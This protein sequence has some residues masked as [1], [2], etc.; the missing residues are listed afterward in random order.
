[1]FTSRRQQEHHA[2]Q[3]REHAEALK[4]K[5]ERREA[6]ERRM[7]KQTE[8]A[9]RLKAQRARRHR[10]MLEEHARRK[11]KGG[12]SGHSSWSEYDYSYYKPSSEVPRSTTS[13][14]QERVAVVRYEAGWERMRRLAD[15]G[16][17]LRF[18]DIPWP[19]VHPIATPYE[20]KLQRSNIKQFILSGWLNLGQDR[21]MR[22]RAFILQ[23]HPDKF[24]GR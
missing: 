17:R 5:A 8:D 11:G 16:A 10:E 20:L 12:W 23:W 15:M 9:A 13:Q 22:L 2:R 19:T 21:R 7:K 18:S 6:H 3:E 4:R 1:M 14:E 24:I